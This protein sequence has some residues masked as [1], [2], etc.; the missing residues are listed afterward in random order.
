ME[1]SAESLLTVFDS[2]E[3]ETKTLIFFILIK[4]LEHKV[5]Y[6]RSMFKNK[7]FDNLRRE[8]HRKKYNS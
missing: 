5:S 7:K 1:L 3:N 4:V 8:Y 6:L 2:T